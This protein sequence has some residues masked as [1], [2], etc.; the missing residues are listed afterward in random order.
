MHKKLSIKSPDNPKFQLTN[1]NS[2]NKKCILKFSMCHDKYPLWEL[3]K[4]DLKEFIKFAKK[5]LNESQ[6]KQIVLSAQ[7]WAIDNKDMLPKRGG[8]TENVKVTIEQLYNNGYLDNEVVDLNNN[9]KVSKCSYV[10][11]ALIDENKNSGNVYTYEFIEQ[12]C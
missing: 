2:D 10:N 11:I 1:E 3:Q 6:K 8:N 7:N 4:E 12:D 5:D 9:N